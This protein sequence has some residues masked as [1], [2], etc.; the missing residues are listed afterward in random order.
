MVAFFDAAHEA[1]LLNNATKLMVMRTL[2]VAMPEELLYYARAEQLSSLFGYTSHSCPVQWSTDHNLLIHVV[3]EQERT[4]EQV[5]LERRVE[6][7]QAL[8]RASPK[9]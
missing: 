7:V 1:S 4:N 6:R 9:G 2:A 8:H 3:A 5:R